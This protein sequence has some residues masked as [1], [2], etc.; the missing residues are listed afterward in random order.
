[1]LMMRSPRAAIVAFAFAALNLA[2]FGYAIALDEPGHALIHGAL[3]V[4]SGGLGIWLRQRR[5]TPAPAA[6]QE[7]LLDEVDAPR[8]ELAEVQERLDFTERV[9][10]EQRDPLNVAPPRR[11]GGA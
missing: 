6:D 7:A 9:L 5:A 8:G 2:G 11:E 10:T 1:M 4:A 3:A